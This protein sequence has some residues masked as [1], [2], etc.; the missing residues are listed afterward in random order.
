MD[1][2]V[3]VMF[4]VSGPFLIRHSDTIAHLSPEFN[5]KNHDEFDVHIESIWEKRR[6]ENPKLFNGTK[7]RLHSVSH[8]SN[9]PGCKTTF[10]LGITCYRDFIST[11]WAPNAEDIL[12]KGEQ[13]YNNTQAFMS[14]A[15]GVGAL[16]QTTDNHVIFLKRSIH[17]GEA[18]GLWDIPG[19]HAE[20]QELVGDLPVEN[21]DVTKMDP[22]KVIEEMFDSIKREVIDEVNIPSSC[23]SEPELCGIARNTTA[24]GRPS[25]EFVIRCSLNSEEVKA[26]YHQGNQSEADES[27]SICLLPLE[28]VIKM[29]SEDEFW[30][31]MAPSAKG[32]IILYRLYD[33]KVTDLGQTDLDNDV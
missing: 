27:T 21:I 15:M 24:A 13:D 4:T 29:K 31:N 6:L 28:T 18:K 1:P 7:F 23:L 5:K 17:C 26:K 25:V 11:N 30:Q 2:D 20:P 10:N 19:G 3:S 32:C 8:E 12:R 14:D 9:G 33:T 22:V 16:V